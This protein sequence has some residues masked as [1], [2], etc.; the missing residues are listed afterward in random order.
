MECMQI[1]PALHTHTLALDT[2]S[3]HPGDPNSPGK[4]SGEGGRL[5]LLHTT[6]ITDQSMLLNKHYPFLSLAPSSPTITTVLKSLQSILTTDRITI[7][8][9]V[10]FR[11]QN[12]TLLHLFLLQIHYYCRQCG[13][14]H[15]NW[16]IIYHPFILNLLFLLLKQQSG[17]LRAQK[18]VFPK[19]LRAEAALGKGQ[20]LIFYQGLQN[21]WARN[22]PTNL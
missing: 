7:Q 10:H 22:S 21:V 13:T 20:T 6:H 12:Y 5:Q 19:L 4:D 17:P 3:H 16:E 15:L 2:G 14:K 9:Q 8:F 18:R 1:Q 11:E